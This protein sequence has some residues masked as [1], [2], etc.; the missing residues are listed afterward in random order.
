MTV[1]VPRLPPADRLRFEITEVDF[2]GLHH[3]RDE[4][5]WDV[6]LGQK[7]PVNVTSPPGVQFHVWTTP[8]EDQLVFAAESYYR[9]GNG[10]PAEF[11]QHRVETQAKAFMQRR[12]LAR[13]A[14]P[15]LQQTISTLESRIARLSKIPAN[16]V[17]AHHRAIAGPQIQV[18]R[19]SLARTK[20]R[21]ARAQHDLSAA[22]AAF[23]ELQEVSDLGNRIQGLA[24]FRYRVYLPIEY[25]GVSLEVDVVETGDE[26]APAAGEA[27][28]FAIGAMKDAGERQS[29]PTD[30]QRRAARQR[31]AEKFQQPY[32]EAEDPASQQRLAQMLLSEAS[33][34]SSDPARR[35]ELLTLAWKLLAMAGEVEAALDVAGQ[36]EHLYEVDRMPL[37]AAVVRRAAKAAAERDGTSGI[38]DAVVD[39]VD[40]AVLEDEYDLAIELLGLAKSL[41]EKTAASPRP[42]ELQE[43]IEFLEA[44][45][46]LAEHLATLPFTPDDAAAHLRVGRTALVR[47]RPWNECI[48]VLA[49]GGQHPLA[50]AARIDRSAPEDPAEQLELAERWYALGESESA[51]LRPYLR[52]RAGK[53]YA[54][55]LPHLSGFSK[56]KAEAR[57]ETVTPTGREAEAE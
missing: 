51:E 5:R 45:Q 44:E 2:A 43:R 8:M 39:V 54:E 52:Q 27:N 37:R 47:G 14:I 42:E 35:F 34:T 9:M 50:E 16:A 29:V 25:D 36:M 24:P 4:E 15:R 33:R 10:S 28:A 3:E 13:A 38:A 18:M 17:T 20:N 53:W 48:N 6:R 32:Q 19:V 7:V 41:Q 22:S 26:S 46:Q 55:A 57:L 30:E 40:E 1:E 23:G 31:L 21:L 11:S 49:K 12:R 56:D